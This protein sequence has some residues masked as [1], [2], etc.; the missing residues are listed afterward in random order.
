[1]L[2]TFYII[3]HDRPAPEILESDHHCD[4]IALVVRDPENFHENILYKTGIR[5]DVHPV[6]W[7][8]RYIR[9]GTVLASIKE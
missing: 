1:M 6:Q 4:K 7:C 9:R 8:W 2:L 5:T 3:T